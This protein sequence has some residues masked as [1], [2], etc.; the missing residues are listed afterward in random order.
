MTNDRSAIEHDSAIAIIGMAGRFPGAR[1]VNQFWLNLREGVES[2]SFF[3]REESAALGVS[4][5]L[6]NHPDFVNA[7]GMLEDIDKFDAAFFGFN[8]REAEILD[9]QHR[10]LLECAWEALEN[11]GYNP[12]TYSKLIGLYAGV[13]NPAY[14]FNNLATNPDLVQSL[15]FDQLMIANTSEFLTTRVSYKLNLKGPSY[16]VLSACSTS[17]VAVH[18]ACQSILSGE[19]DIALA[20]GVSISSQQGRG[21]IFREGGIASK[22]G[23]THAF[24]A[25]AMG[26][27]GGNGVGLVVLKQL[28]DAIADGDHIHAV[29]RGSAINNDGSTKIGYTAPSIEGEARA[30]SEALSVSE[31]HPETVTYIETHG[32]ATRLGD[33][34]EVAALAKVFGPKTQK[35]KFCGLGSVK[36]N[37]GHLN[38]A[39]GVAGLIK[40]VLSLEN[41]AIPP[42]LNFKT[43]NPAI[44]FENG[45]FYVNTS[46]RKWQ[47]NGT[48]R[49]AGVSSF[50]IGGT[51][52]HLI[53]EEAPRR[54][55]SKASER[56]YQLLTLSARTSTALERATQNL[57]AYLKEN[58]NVNLA[59]LAYVH[60]VGRKHFNQRRAFVCADVKNAIEILEG[61]A[62]LSGSCQE[63]ETRVAFMFPGQGA[64]YV[65]MARELYAFVPAF[66]EPLDTCFEFLKPVLGLD[67]RSILFPTQEDADNAAL[68]LEHTSITQVV[69]FVVEYALS[70]MLQEW[71]IK[72]TAMIGHSIGEYVAACLAG[73]FSLEDA[74][75]LVA[76][77]GRLMGS[78][79]RGAMCSIPLPATEVTAM[80]GP[81]LSLASINGASLC[82]ASGPVADIEQLE[83]QLLE[84]QIVSRRLHTSHAFHSAMVEPVIE[85]FLEVL[86]DV[87]FNAPQLPYISNVT[88]TWIKPAEATD[89]NYWTRHLRETV[90]F[91]KGVKELYKETDVVLLEVGPRV[92][93]SLIKPNGTAVP[94]AF[95]CLRHPSELQSDVAFLLQ[96]LG[97]LWL[98]GVNINWRNFYARERRQRLPLPTYPFERQR[99]WVEARTVSTQP[100]PTTTQKKTNVSDWFYV[101]SWKRS[102]LLHNV[103]H[104]NEDC[105]V[106]AGDD[107]LGHE[108]VESLAKRTDCVVVKADQIDYQSLLQ[109]LRSQEFAPRRI[110]YLWDSVKSEDHRELIA[111]AQAVS[112]NYPN[113]SIGLF[114]VT[115]N[116]H[117]VTGVELMIPERATIVGTCRAISQQHPNIRCRTIDVPTSSPDDLLLEFGH[118]SNET[119]VAYRGKHRWTQIFEPVRPLENGRSLLKENGVYL[120][121][122]GL[123]TLALTIAEELA[124]SSQAKLILVSRS[125]LPE[126][127]KLK[128][129]EDLGSEILVQRADV[130]NE[131]EMRLAVACALKRFGHID[132]V[133]HAAGVD[134]GE[135]PFRA[136]VEGLTVLEKV[137]GKVKPDFFLLMS[138]VSAITGG[139]GAEAESFLDAFATDRFRR[140]GTR[141]VSVNW[142]EW[143]QNNP[144]SGITDTEIVEVFRKVVSS[145]R[146]PQLVVSTRDLQ[147]RLDSWTIEELKS[148]PETLTANLYQ[149]PE[150]NNTFVAPVTDLE[151][152]ISAIWQS[153][154]GIQEVGVFDNFF[155]LG[156]N[157][158][159]G[160]QLN[161]RLRQDFQVEIPLRTLFESPTVS[162]LAALV[163]RAQ[164]EPQEE[165][166]YNMPIVAHM[167]KSLDQLLSEVE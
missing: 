128:A 64:Q 70:R 103:A 55:P 19:C 89:P 6:V 100:Q 86:R 112:T 120:L 61:P 84:K 14:L 37:I 132:G 140:N 123:G 58:P 166:P 91:A 151:V 135:D 82:V 23:R 142:D 35:K 74:L 80:L 110:V 108:L 63:T 41:E 116:L 88:G 153:L 48:P 69:L 146:T 36:T 49:R 53:L 114:V 102:P 117:D 161:A 32:T 81:G 163:E 15:G 18:I 150:L 159:L 158:L 155:E 8:P 85:P 22:D 167:D 43:P 45:P 164:A 72:P 10:F 141:W 75:R 96:T 125:T 21:Y 71:G 156:G 111:L 101:P 30:I 137:F 134:D 52:A 131:E 162:E 124:R 99:F 46:L 38:T 157:S 115:A 139:P 145:V 66:R 65:D 106:F 95:P 40:T 28:H 83:A 118:E 126:Q 7:E 119:T 17:L 87:K 143:Q 144:R 130:T 1:D 93:S 68:Q 77:R 33:P 26:T 44:D 2:I 16:V 67:L 149:R 154:L 56:P 107:E 5:A 98:Q 13:S 29:I 31:I 79:E 9:P 50:G 136:K 20:G 92:L 129:I 121:T 24:D 76:A 47:T 54:E 57:L 90:Q 152:Q 104:E 60:H 39:A 11:A 25:N 42:S 113:E 3:S 160:I 97:R 34:I 94:K 147:A 138:S 73:V 27:V 4:E 78:V 109:E 59:D 62:K 133:I 12:E 105:L 165:S 51:N 148:E 122:G 127:G